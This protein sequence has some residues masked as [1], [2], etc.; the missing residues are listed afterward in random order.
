M[1][2]FSDLGTVLITLCIIVVHMQLHGTPIFGNKTSSVKRGT[3][4]DTN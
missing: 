1:A 2:M 4:K 3:Y